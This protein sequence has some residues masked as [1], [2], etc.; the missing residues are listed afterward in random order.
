MFGESIL[1]VAAHPDDEVLGMG[2]TIR[3]LASQGKKVSVLFL[4][5]GVSSRSNLR[6]PLDARRESAVSALSKLGC[7][8]I[9]FC[10]FP[11]NKL[12]TIPIL[13]I[14]KAVDNKIDSFEPISVFTHFPF[15]LN[16]DHQIVSE[17]VQVASR[18]KSGSSVQQL[19]FFEVLS[20]TGWKFGSRAFTPN[21]FVQIEDEFE[22]KLDSLQD[23]DLEME[24]YPDA[25]SVE[26]VSALATLRG[27]FVGRKKSEAFEIGFIRN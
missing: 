27:A 5:D 25:R 22:N 6:Q 1:V 16:I 17:A 13:E 26:A 24:S 4:S 9:E 19:F 21:L 2:G 20:S 7:S 10:D 12:D 3:K 23:Y 8:D 11:D 14:C 18:P 15:D